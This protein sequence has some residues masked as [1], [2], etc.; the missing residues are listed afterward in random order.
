MPDNLVRQS[1]FKTHS[2]H[3]VST[4]QGDRRNCFSL[5][6]CIQISFQ[7]SLTTKEPF[8]QTVVV[9]LQCVSRGLLTCPAWKLPIHMREN[10]FPTMPSLEKV[11]NTFFLV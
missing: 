7:V 3:K 9:V 4:P 1:A 8:S 10:T 2:L 11:R 6:C 5:S